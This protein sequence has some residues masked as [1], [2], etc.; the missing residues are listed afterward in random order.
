MRILYI[1][2]LY[3][4]INSSA[5]IR[6]N[7]LVKGLIELGHKVYV[8]TIDWGRDESG[9]LNIENNG[10]IYK[11][12]LK[13][14]NRIN[15][16][17]DN[18]AKKSAF[19]HSLSV[20]F[21]PILFFP[22][23]IK[24]WIKQFKYNE[25]VNKYDIIISSSDTKS[26]HFIACKIKQ[27]HPSIKWIQIW[28]DPWTYDINTPWYMRPI[29]SFYESRLFRLA[30]KIVYVSEL[31]YLLMKKK[32]PI[33]SQKMFYVPRSFYYQCDKVAT[34]D[35]NNINILYTGTLSYGRNITALIN[36]INMYNEIGTCKIELHIYGN[37]TDVDQN[38]SPYVFHHEAVD[39]SKIKHI[40]SG[41]DIFLFISNKGDTSQIPGKL[42][43]YLG[44][45]QPILCLCD[46]EQTKLINY[47][48]TVPKC[49]VINN[50]EQSIFDL[51]NSLDQAILDKY[52]GVCS[53]YSPMSIAKQIL[54]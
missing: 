22:D 30:D 50:N 14:I 20:L 37:S 18:V 43:D 54:E 53:E 47:L 41:A 33:Y 5:A 21:K 35:S 27:E 15:H 23:N 38:D 16:Y 36:A 40:Y 29:T 52:S 1:T 17:K 42:Y 44:C 26:S 10:H 51:L 19:I 31:T 46:S 25:I 4:R 28:G 45:S 8:Q 34:I 13:A 9:F 7:A 39:Y 48:K 12:K 11:Y 3:T 2:S 32:Q 24:E 6:N 49:I